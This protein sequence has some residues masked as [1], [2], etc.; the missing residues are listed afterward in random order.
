M[1]ADSSSNNF[2]ILQKVRINS[3]VVGVHA[4]PN[5]CL[6]LGVPEYSAREIDVYCLV[7]YVLEQ[8]SRA[9][10]GCEVVNSTH[11][12]LNTVAANIAAWFVPISLHERPSVSL[13]N[14]IQ[15]IQFFG[16]QIIAEK[17][18]YLFI[19]TLFLSLQSCLNTFLL[20]W[21]QIHRFLQS[22]S[23]LLFQIM[24]FFLFNFLFETQPMFRTFCGLES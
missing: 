24:H 8:N 19:V 22:L 9:L 2:K 23:V 12:K 14:F 6:S 5:I 11:S 15:V 18:F 16:D 1:L 7:I 10:F 20:R 13:S 17:L 21:Y 3:R 4:E